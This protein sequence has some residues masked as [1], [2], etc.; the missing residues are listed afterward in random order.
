MKSIISD[1]FSECFCSVIEFIR[2]AE[3]SDQEFQNIREKLTCKKKRKKGNFYEYYK[4]DEQYLN[5]IIA[6]YVALKT[7]YKTHSHYFREPIEDIAKDETH[8]FYNIKDIQ[9]PALMKMALSG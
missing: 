6:F 9:E 1:R 5:D 8:N 3:I 4:I 2:D 7:T